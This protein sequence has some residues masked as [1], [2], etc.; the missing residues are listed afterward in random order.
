MPRKTTTTSSVTN[1]IKTAALFT[2]LILARELLSNQPDLIDQLM[3]SSTPFLGMRGY[4]SH[5]Y[6]WRLQ[7]ETTCKNGVRASIVVV[8]GACP[9]A[10]S[11]YS[12]HNIPMTAHVQSLVHKL[13]A[14]TYDYAS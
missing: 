10:A 8:L 5:L 1:L 12:T 11:I 14:E 3:L 4:A 2:E 9:C 13:D 7:Q 6:Q